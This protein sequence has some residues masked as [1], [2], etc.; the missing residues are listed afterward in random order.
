MLKLDFRTKLIMTIVLSVVLLLG[1]FDKKLFYMPII[2]SMIP[3]V[4]LMISGYYSQAVR[5]ILFIFIIAL[6]QKYMFL[7]AKGLILNF[8]I[9]LSSFALKLIP[10]A[11]MGS[12]TLLT[13]TMG[14]ILY[15]MKKMKI[16]AQIIV[17]VSVMARFFYTIKIDY[18]QIKIAMKLQG[19]TTFNLLFKPY[20][21]FE[22]RLVPLLMCLTKTADEVAISAITRGLE[23]GTERTSI[24]E[25]K[26]HFI[27]YIFLI[28]TGII[29][30]IYIM[31]GA[32][33]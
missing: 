32:K 22:Y 30:V 23:I 27:D 28:F 11:M 8:Y 25:R 9:V 12:Y 4:L 16:P 21:L 33:C 5:G 6:I 13:S 20:K 1:N 18:E 17:P 7:N 10:S 2:L 31:G 29:I 15:S 19:L 26:L 14:E 3:C 24:H